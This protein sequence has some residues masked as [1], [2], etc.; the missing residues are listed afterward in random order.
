V[1]VL[2]EEP[3]SLR[4]LAPHAPPALE[5][6]VRRCLEKERDARFQ[7]AAEL[8]EALRPLASARTRTSLERLRLAKDNPIAAGVDL[9]VDAAIGS[10][11]EP[12][13]VGIHPSSLRPGR[14]AGER[15][16]RERQMPTAPTAFSPRSLPEVRSPA[17]RRRVQIA[18]GL[19]S[20]AAILVVF[21]V[22]SAAKLAAQATGI[23]PSAIGEPDTARAGAAGAGA[24]RSAASAPATPATGA[25][26]LDAGLARP[27]PRR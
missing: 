13:Q 10:G 6:I 21:G 14:E 4:A 15:E 3:A 18:I 9:V 2:S 26:P 25:T 8:A 11:G 22:L 5:R 23:V 24:A 20:V 12:L 1:K 17:S 27:W 7:T 19:G 16:V